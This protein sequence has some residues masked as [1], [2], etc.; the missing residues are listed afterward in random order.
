LSPNILAIRS[1]ERCPYC[2]EVHVGFRRRNLKE[3]NQLEDPDV[4]GEDTRKIDVK[5]HGMTWT[6][7]IWLR[8]GR[9]AY[10]CE[11]GHETLQSIKCGRFMGWLSNCWFL[12]DCAMQLVV[13][14][15]DWN[16]NRTTEQ[17]C[18]QREQVKLFSRL[19]V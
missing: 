16:S 15:F 12:K 1:R 9:V 14:L 8:I 2:G 17:S 13:P 10:S 6:G 11:N 19:F 5:R 18:L 4:V 3:S 7:L